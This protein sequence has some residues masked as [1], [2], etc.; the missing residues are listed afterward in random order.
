MKWLHTQKKQINPSIKRGTSSLNLPRM[1]EK[2]RI[3]PQT[4]LSYRRFYVPPFFF[5][6]DRHFLLS[7][8][9]FITRRLPLIALRVMLAP[10]GWS[11]QVQKDFT[12]LGSG[13]ALGV[14]P[15]LTGMD[16]IPLFLS[17]PPLSLSL[18][19]RRACGL[20]FLPA[21]PLSLAAVF[22]HSFKEKGMMF[23]WK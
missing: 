13:G 18:S 19:G 10:H 16:F 15:W 12:T 5:K 6:R 23:W 11:A 7:G 9:Q 8:T 14:H 1:C 17:L 2:K 3:K 22:I 21:L 4:C 20:C